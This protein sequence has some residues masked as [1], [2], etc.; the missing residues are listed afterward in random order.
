MR[1]LKQQ[2]W[3][4]ECAEKKH[5]AAKN[6]AVKEEHITKQQR[7][8]LLSS[9]APGRM[10]HLD[11][12]QR[13]QAALAA[14]LDP[15]AGC[16]GGANRCDGVAVESCGDGNEKTEGEAMANQDGMKGKVQ[17]KC[18]TVEERRGPRQTMCVKCAAVSRAEKIAAWKEKKA[19]ERAQEPG[20]R[21]HARKQTRKKI[22]ETLNAPLPGEGL[23][24]P[25]LPVAATHPDPVIT[26]GDNC[27]LH[28]MFGPMR[29]ALSSISARH[30]L[31]AQRAMAA[32]N[33]LADLQEAMR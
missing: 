12:A 4:R 1:S 8:E 15:W 21:E 18:G 30:G 10:E 32:D 31:I 7:A 17:C 24:S 13:R 14:R 5:T 19:E 33:A 16:A 29:S 22:Q 27:V 26:V 23:N 20:S 28:G 25:V 3:C 2:S 11:P 6:S 9:P